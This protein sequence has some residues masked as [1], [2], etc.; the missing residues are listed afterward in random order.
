M[1]EY[2]VKIF[3]LIFFASLANINAL[4]ITESEAE[5]FL[6]GEYNRVFNYYGDISTTGYLELN[7]IFAFKLGF[8]LGKSAANTIIKTH[9][10][11]AYFPFQ[12]IPLKFSVL[13]IYNVIPDYNNHTYTI[14]PLI[15]FNTRIA[16]ISIGPSLRL[17]SFFI[18][19][20]QF[21]PILSLSAY[22]NFIN[23]DKLRIGIGASN[24][25]DFQAKNFGAYSLNINALIRMDKNWQIL[26]EIELMQSGGDGFSSV[27]FGFGWKGGA[28]YTW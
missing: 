5:V 20:A 3:L 4:E 1:K 23:N 21:E 9:L 15:S 18:E 26:N 24:F 8:S 16:G 2:G 19:D 14:L 10:S 6:R 13:Y 28:R 27:F 17:T 11:A 7:N 22:L 12:L 25:N